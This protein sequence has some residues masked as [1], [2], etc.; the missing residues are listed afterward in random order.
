[1]AGKGAEAR[2]NYKERKE[3]REAAGP[4][5]SKWVPLVVV[6]IAGMCL[7]FG[8]GFAVAAGLWLI[9]RALGA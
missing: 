3:K 9:A 8:L 5:R 7:G 2:R 4:N 1:M 6:G